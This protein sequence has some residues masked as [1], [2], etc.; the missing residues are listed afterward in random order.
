M[1]KISF[2][3]SSS[4]C[5][6]V[7]DPP[8]SAKQEVPEWYKKSPSFDQ[9]K[10]KIDDSGRVKNTELKMCMPFFDALSGGYIQKTWT[11]IFIE[12]DPKSGSV[13]FYYALSP[14]IM[15]AREKVHIPI[16]TNEFYNIEFA[17]IEPWVP[18]LPSGYSMLY[19]H[20]FNRL[21]LPF[22]SLSAIIDS[23]RYYH[24]PSGQYPFYIKKGFS[25][26]IPAGTPMYQMTP[27]KRDSWTS[28]KD[29]F[30]EKLTNKNHFSMYKTFWGAY[31][32]SFWQRKNFN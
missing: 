14:K 12:N 13:K 3:P 2:I 15:R 18:K 30:D 24:T 16:D 19:T 1:K 5:E 8:C 28:K 10:L 17:W 6:L 29:K 25:G 20:P 31:K 26:I 22:L 23:D 11:D 32:N 21:D 4:D 27:F 7:V 9:K